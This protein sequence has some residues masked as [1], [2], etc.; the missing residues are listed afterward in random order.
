MLVFIKG[1]AL[2]FFFAIKIHSRYFYSVIATRTA[3]LRSHNI[4][5]IICMCENKSFT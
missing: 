1:A 5:L 2:N 4:N 3:P